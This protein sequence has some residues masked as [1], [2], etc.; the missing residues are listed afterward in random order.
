MAVDTDDQTLRALVSALSGLQEAEVALGE[1]K[2]ALGDVRE[3]SKAAATRWGDKVKDAQKAHNRAAAQ[4]AK[5]RTAERRIM[6]EYVP[7]ELRNARD[8]AAA[9]VRGM[10]RTLQAELAKLDG[11]R[12]RVAEGRK[13]REI[14]EVDPR[15]IGTP[16]EGK[17]RKRRL[18]PSMSEEEAAEWLRSADAE[19]GDL[20]NLR[21]DLA[22]AQK[23]L[24]AA[25]AAV[26]SAFAD[27]VARGSS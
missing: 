4:L 3:R 6:A 2:A 24:A 1:A 23:A 21:V 27:A 26:D 9:T 22:K 25:Q 15:Y 10:E 7:L 13:R 19:E 20:Q 12:R 5:F 8:K 14:T 17:R 16:E 11:I 18:A